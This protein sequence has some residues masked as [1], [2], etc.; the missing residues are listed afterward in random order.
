V[1]AY[2]R[3]LAELRRTDASEFGGKS[4][5]LGDLLS[6]GIPVPDGF[7]IGADAFRTF[8]AETGLD[9]TIASALSRAPKGDVEA[10]NAASKAIDEA[11]RFAPLPDAVRGEVARSY[12]ALG[13]LPPVA[14]RSSALGEDSHDATFAGQ[15]ESFLWIRGVEQ[16]CDAVRDCWV[17]LYTPR[18]ISYRA[19]LGAQEEAAMG[20]TIQEM[21]DAEVSGVMF[22]C[23]PVSGDPS[24]V[25]VNASW[26][27][28]IAVVGGE[29]TPDD[30]LVSKV[31]GEVVRQTVNS[32]EIEY[33]PDPAG[34]G[35]V[36][37]EV[38]AGRRER[39]CLD[40]EGIAALVE[41]AVRIER[42]FGS[43]QDIEW[44]I[45]RGR[46]LPESLLMLQSRPVT[47]L[48]KDPPKLSG[49]AISLV[50]GTFGAAPRKED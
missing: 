47:T 7:A 16:L 46:S 17:S 29:T 13:D 50:M 48:T 25:A 33:V 20:V 2:T 10:A 21:V 32:K 34:R 31:T 35:T 37:K 41:A 49:S 19:E 38:P 6:A 14:V 36:R 4:S 1:A 28:G 8:V 40:E 26:G 24:M 30:F 11:M 5:N 23:N 15:Q 45:A 42:H 43:H 22:T 39:P 12:G 18:A 9:G 3:P 27:L 44:A